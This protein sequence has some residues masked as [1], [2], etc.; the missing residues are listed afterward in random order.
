M[1]TLTADLVVLPPTA[2][3]EPARPAHEAPTATTV[4]FT[5]D[6]HT[7]ALRRDVGDVLAGRMSAVGLDVTWVDA[8]AGLLGTRRRFTVRGP[9]QLVHRLITEI[10][11]DLG[12]QPGAVALPR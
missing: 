9:R 8:R 2:V 10:G 1:S 6:L 11:R 7:G 3:V 4:Q 5:F 12:W